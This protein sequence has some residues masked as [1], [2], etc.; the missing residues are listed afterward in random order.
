MFVDWYL[1]M[2]GLYFIIHTRILILECQLWWWYI[3]KMVDPQKL[4]LSNSKSASKWCCLEQLFTKPLDEHIDRWCWCNTCNLR[5][6]ISHQTRGIIWLWRHWG[7][8]QICSKYKHPLTNLVGILM[9]SLLFEALLLQVQTSF[10]WTA[11]QQH[12][13]GP[14]NCVTW[15]QLQ[16]PMWWVMVWTSSEISFS[17]FTKTWISV[18]SQFNTHITGRMLG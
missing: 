4:I 6:T 8:P 3:V 15:L 9:E 7:I 1:K 17:W 5:S 16:P 11:M 14:S 10:N 13:V 18:G 2:L 12:W